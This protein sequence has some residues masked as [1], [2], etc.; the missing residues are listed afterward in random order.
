[1]KFTKNAAI[2]SFAIFGSTQNYAS[3]RDLFEDE[4]ATRNWWE[5]G[6]ADPILD[7]IALFYLGHTWFQGADIGE[8]LETMYRTNHS[9]PWSWHAEFTKTA[10]RLEDV[11]KTFED[12]GTDTS[13]SGTAVV[14]TLGSI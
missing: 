9:D 2:A 10:E 13:D 14:D 7:E 8:V 6:M 3:A 5:F 4:G 12:E 11:G 1:M